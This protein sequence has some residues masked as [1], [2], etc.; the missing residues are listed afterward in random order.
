VHIFSIFGRLY[1]I[2]SEID[3]HI[4]SIS[5]GTGTEAMSIAAVAVTTA[6]SAWLSSTRVGTEMDS[7]T[8]STKIY[9]SWSV[10][11]GRP[12]DLMS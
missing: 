2:N 10:T 9:L 8:V 6:Q 12:E 3:M 4:F 1:H 7:S 5:M 11:A